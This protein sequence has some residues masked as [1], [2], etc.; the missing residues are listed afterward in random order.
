MPK[1]KIISKTDGTNTRRETGRFAFDLGL[2]TL[3]D[4][5]QNTTESSETRIAAAK[6][7]IEYGLKL[8][9]CDPLGL[10]DLD[11]FDAD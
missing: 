2:S 5:V 10:D 3:S 7:L 6:A 11:L 9:R 1:S 8:G 4:I